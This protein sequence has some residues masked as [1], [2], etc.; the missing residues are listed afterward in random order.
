MGVDQAAAWIAPAAT[1][2]AAMMTAANL[3]PRV[4]GFGFVVFLVGSLAWCVI[5]LGTHQQN[6][7]WSNG[8]LTVVNVIGIWRWLGRQA[9]YQKAGQAAVT[10][11][12]RA[13]VPT[14][15]SIQALPGSK[16]LDDGGATVGVIVDAMMR[17]ADAGL[18]YVVV[19]EGGVGGVGERLHALGAADLVFAE[20]GVTSRLG[21]S[22]LAE[23]PV[24]SPGEWPA[25]L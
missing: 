17:C 25:S 8:F 23:R 3:G 4:T 6:L 24:L 19:S 22:E 20:D 16:L 12:A 7:L 1:M 5:G 9:K 2:V 11:S 10:E 15:T 13:H 18:A 21:A 14:L